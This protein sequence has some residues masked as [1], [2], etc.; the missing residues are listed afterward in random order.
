MGV[1]SIGG[2]LGLFGGGVA[3][4]VCGVQQLWDFLSWLGLGCWCFGVIWGCLSSVV[5]ARLFCG[6]NWY[7][8]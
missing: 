1:G 6:F 7:V 8:M 5:L 2:Y 4:E 3:G